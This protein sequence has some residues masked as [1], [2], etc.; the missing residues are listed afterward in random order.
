MRAVLPAVVAWAAVSVAPLAGAAASEAAAVA[1]DPVRSAVDEGR[2]VEAIQLVEGLHERGEA[3]AESHYLLG[4][5]YQIRL[6]EVGLLSKRGVAG[7]LRATLEEALR[8]DPQHVGAHEELA[9]FFHYAPAIVGGS[10]RRAAEQIERLASFSPY[11]A[12]RVRGRHA[13]DAG[14]YLQAEEHLSRALALDDRDATVWFLRA[15]ARMKRREKDAA[16]LADYE[17]AL[18]LGYDE[19]VAYYQIGRLCVRLMSCPERGEEVLRQFIA[20]SEGRDQAIGRYR[21]AQL[22]EQSGRL[23]EARAEAR[24]ALGL[25]PD[26][27][28]IQALL[29][30]VEKKLAGAPAGGPR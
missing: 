16:A 17:R 25:E 24:E 6:D 18:E 2:A 23:T 8:I 22:F 10:E 21:L 3:S 15:N 11:D 27:R 14:E 13:Y 20:H 28:D 19:P 1:L 9:D 12:H 5:A 26:I 4:L 7:R 29:E 30:R